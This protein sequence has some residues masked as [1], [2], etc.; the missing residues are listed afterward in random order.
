MSLARPS[1]GHSRGSIS[2]FSP[3][4]Q[5]HQPKLQDHKN[6]A[7]ASHGA[8]VPVYSHYKLV[9]E[10]AVIDKATAAFTEASLYFTVNL[11]RNTEHQNIT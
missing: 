9:L 1:C 7:S 8:P 2:H 5:R 10:K 4:S 3:H 6:G 11:A